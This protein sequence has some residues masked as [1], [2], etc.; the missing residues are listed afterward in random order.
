MADKRLVDA[1]ALINDIEGWRNRIG[2]T[3]NLSDAI[4][5]NV[6]SS[7]MDGINES[8]TIDAVPVVRCRECRLWRKIEPHTGKCPF[9]I[10]EHQ[11]T[12]DDHYCSLG[13]KRED[14]EYTTL[15]DRIKLILKIMAEFNE[16]NSD[17]DECPFFDTWCEGEPGGGCLVEDLTDI[18]RIA[19]E[20]DLLGKDD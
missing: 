18:V 14:G 1:N 13:E 2:D 11:Y 7:V 3:M 5:K 16:E 17:C 4:I 15:K 9:L 8:E 19:V 20:K 10:G 6:L 12:T